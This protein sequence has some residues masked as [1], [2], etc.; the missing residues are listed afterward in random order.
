MNSLFSVFEQMTI[1]D[2]IDILIVSII[3][4]NILVIF[5]GT[6]ATQM[7]IGL[8]AILILFWFSVRYEL[9]SLNW[10]LAHFFESFFIIFVIVFQDQ[11]RQ[12]LAFFGKTNFIGRTDPELMNQTIEEVVE[13]CGALS[14]EKTGAL[15]VFERQNGL[16]NYA[17]TGTMIESKIHSDLI[18]SI[19]QM[20]SPLHDG[21][22]IIGGDTIRAAGC[23]LPLSKNF[24]IDRHLGTRHRAALGVTESTDSVAII[25]S[26]EKGS[27][28]VC[29]NGIFYQ[30][31]NE[32]ALGNWLRRFL[33]SESLLSAELMDNT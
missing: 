11:I 9:L 26:E 23:F 2:V 1:K 31:E 12:A 8:A 21:A 28:K 33:Q 27:I 4:Y 5:R 20:N 25:V 17:T 7:L 16:M 30:M 6:R 18:Y 13:A 14:R 10:V 22:I 19:F 32:T 24:E 29:F 15:I 3:F